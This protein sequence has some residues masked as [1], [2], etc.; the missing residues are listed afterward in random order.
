MDL[1]PQFENLYVTFEIDVMDPGQAPG[2]GTPEAGGLHYEE[3]RDCV[4][5]LVKRD[6]RVGFD[7][8]EVAPPY[9]S[10]EITVLVAAR[11]IID[12]LAARFPSR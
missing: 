1:I 3:L 7:P 10:S 12:I 8:V 11:L 2:T 6:D 4:T 5:A 9:D